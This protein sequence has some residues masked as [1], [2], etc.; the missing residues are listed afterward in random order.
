MPIEEED[1]PEGDCGVNEKGCPWTCQKWRRKGRKQGTART[2]EE[3]LV[4]VDRHC[5]YQGERLGQL[6]MN[7][8]V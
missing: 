4:D 5:R 8:S 2:G 6:H 7:D 1:S 3:G